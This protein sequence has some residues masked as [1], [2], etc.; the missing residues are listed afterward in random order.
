MSAVYTLTFR[1]EARKPCLCDAGERLDLVVEVLER[2]GVTEPNPVLVLPAGFVWT[3]STKERDKWVDSLARVSRDSRTGMVIGID[4]EPFGAHHLDH[5][6]LDQLESLGRTVLKRAGA[7]L[8]R[9]CAHQR[10]VGVRR[11]R[12]WR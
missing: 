2:L 6:P 5:A 11:W 8:D 3:T 1:D 10:R 7:R 4:L 12:R 9:D